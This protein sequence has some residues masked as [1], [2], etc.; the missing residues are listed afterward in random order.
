MLDL[1]TESMLPPSKLKQW[2]YNSISWD[3]I[4]CDN[5]SHSTIGER[6]EMANDFQVCVHSQRQICLKKEEQKLMWCD[7]HGNKHY[8]KA[9]S[10][11][12]ANNVFQRIHTHQLS[13][14][15]LDSA[16]EFRWHESK[17]A[18]YKWSR[19]TAYK[20]CLF[21]NWHCLHR[22]WREQKEK[23]WTLVIL[24]MS[25]KKITG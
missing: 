21:G 7:Y 18:K 22:K 15:T 12:Q 24:K 11:W 20:W 6:H 23:T 3:N 4:S 5:L 9:E 8:A 10:S 13:F 1:C 25:I 16:S 14:T 2:L 19:T 17:T